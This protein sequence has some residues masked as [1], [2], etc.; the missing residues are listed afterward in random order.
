MTEALGS[1]L[2][3]QGIRRA[4]LENLLD[5]LRVA[6]ADRYPLERELGR[7]GMATVYLAQDPKHHR[8]VAVKVLRPELVAML[9]AERFLLE[10]QIAA[11]L[12]HPHILPL[13][14]SG[15]VDGLL[16]DVM[17]HIV[18]ESL[19]QRLTREQQLPIAEALRLAQQVASA[20]DYAHRHGI[21]HRDIKPENILLHEGEALVADFGIALAVRAAGGERLTETGLSLGTSSYMSPEQAMGD[22][23]IDGRSDV[24]SLGCVL[25]EML[26]GEPPYTGANAQAVIARILTE[27]P[28]DL[29]LLRDTVSPGLDHAV[30]RSLAKL[31]A[32]RYNTATEFSDA[33]ARAGADTWAPAVGPPLGSTTLTTAAVPRRL[34]S[35]PRGAPWLLA[36]LALGAAALGWLRPRPAAGVQDTAEVSTEAFQRIVAEK[37]AVVLDTRPHLEYSISHVPGALNVAARP[38]VPQSM[39]VSDVAEVRRLVDA[40]VNRSIACPTAMAPTVPRASASATSCAMRASSTCAAINWAYRCGARSAVSPSSWPMAFDMSLLPTAPPRS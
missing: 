2:G 20:L 21:V 25:F 39:Y 9:G 6:L 24:Y 10:I 23:Q 15:Q 13:Y 22:R 5:R 17:P 4:P 26:A 14:D 31:P 29:R 11:R 1:R 19:R 7:G 40:D 35:M 12:S 38:G 27:R 34:P 16:Y 33:I 36:L 37:Q 8:Q 3:Y 30:A 32:D 18:G 28:R